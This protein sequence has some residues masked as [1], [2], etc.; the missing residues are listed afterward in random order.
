VDNLDA[1]P[2]GVDQVWSH[3]ND[4]CCEMPIESFEAGARESGS[5]TGETPAST[6]AAELSA[7]AHSW[8]RLEQLEQLPPALI[9]QLH[10]AVQAGEKDRL[11]TLIQKVSQLNRAAAGTLQKFADSYDY[12]SL[13]ALLAENKTGKRAMTK[14]P[15]VAPGSEASIIVVDDQPARSM[16]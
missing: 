13:T 2:A 16:H 4:W 9:H 7:A 15:L 12:D 5:P 14:P 11:D 6:E 3:R 10:A 8:V 1:A